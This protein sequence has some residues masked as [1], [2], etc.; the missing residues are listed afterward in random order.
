MPSFSREEAKKLHQKL[1]EREQVQEQ[2]LQSE[3]ERLQELETLRKDLQAER[4]NSQMLQLERKQG[5]VEL[6]MLRQ[7]LMR[8]HD[9]K[10]ML[11]VEKELQAS[12]PRCHIL[13]LERKQGEVE[14]EMLRQDLMRTN[15]EKRMLEVELTR[16]ME[17]FQAA[18]QERQSKLIRE[19]ALQLHQKMLDGE[20]N[21]GN[22]QSNFTRNFWNG[23]E[24]LPESEKA[25]LQETDSLHSEFHVELDML[26]QDLRRT[27][28]EKRLLQVELTRLKELQA[29]GPEQGELNNLINHNKQLEEVIE[30]T[31]DEKRMLEVELTRMMKLFQAADQERQSELLRAQAI[32]LHQAQLAAPT[33]VVPTYAY[34]MHPAQQTAIVPQQ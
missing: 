31:N 34:D 33:F 11:E 5:D 24:L 10:R 30:R 6:D 14:L 29:T 27:H 4:E 23:Q 16:L 7:D 8:T 17:L 9:E 19:Q 18:D 26:R 12:D 28:D 13:H 3:K 22:T 2:L 1:H 15:D 32:Q 25:R 21:L 20:Q